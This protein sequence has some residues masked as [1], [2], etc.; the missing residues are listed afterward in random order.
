MPARA[1]GSLLLLL[2]SACTG[3]AEPLQPGENGEPAMTPVPPVPAMPRVPA[4]P[5]VPAGRDPANCSG[6][7]EVTTWAP[8]GWEDIWGALQLGSRGD[9]VDLFVPGFGEVWTLSHGKNERQVARVE[10][11]SDLVPTLSLA[12]G[13]RDIRYE[14]A[15]LGRAPDGEQRVEAWWYDRFEAR[16]DPSPE[17]TSTLPLEADDVVHDAIL[18]AAGPVAVVVRGG[19]LTV[20]GPAGTWTAPVDGPIGGAAIEPGAGVVTYWT[21]G[22]EVVHSL[23]PFSVETMRPSGSGW[24]GPVCGA[25]GP[26]SAP[27]SDLEVLR[28]GPFLYVVATCADGVTVEQRGLDGALVGSTRFAGLPQAPARAAFDGAEHLVLAT[29]S[30]TEPA[31]TVRLLNPQDLV[32]VR[33]ATPIARDAGWPT[34]GFSLVLAV[35]PS[36]AGRMFVAYSYPVGHG[37]GEVEV[38]R[39]HLC[40][41]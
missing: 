25:P 27:R 18:T 1:L 12:L 14:A 8:E 16:L 28:R 13:P 34:D 7:V 31:P 38:T 17:G 36:G 40:E 29:W 4:G 2:T 23:V 37:A 39:L 19:T 10:N 41:E 21:E 9:E 24:S 26:S 30:E 15:V 6:S 5:P 22:P 20:I 11:L 3:E 32:E 35:S 33:P